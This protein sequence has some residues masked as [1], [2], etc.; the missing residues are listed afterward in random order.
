MRRR[1]PPCV[2]RRGGIEP[3]E[4]RQGIHV[5]FEQ[6]DELGCAA[7]TVM[8]A[9]SV[10]RDAFQKVEYCPMPMLGSRPDPKR[11]KPGAIS[12]G[13]RRSRPLVAGELQSELIAQHLESGQ[14]ADKV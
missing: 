2:R 12:A 8:T 3:R 9:L 1:R 7:L 6:L 5:G 13:S 11:Q 4:V 10:I 14:L